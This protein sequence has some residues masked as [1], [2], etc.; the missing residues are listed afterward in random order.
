MGVPVSE[1]VS[2]WPDVHVDMESRGE[3]FVSRVK[4]VLVAAVEPELGAA[5]ERRVCACEGD[6]VVGCE[7]GMV[8]E[9]AGAVALAAPLTAAESPP[10]AQNRPG[11]RRAKVVGTEPTD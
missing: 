7:V 3:L 8:V 10:T 2:A 1:I 4:W 9:R 5:V 6:D 11:A